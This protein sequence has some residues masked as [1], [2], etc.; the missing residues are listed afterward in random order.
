MNTDVKQLSKYLISF[1]VWL[2]P[3]TQ[4]K[5]A[6]L[7]G[8]SL[9]VFCLQIQQLCLRFPSWCFLWLLIGSLGFSYFFDYSRYWV[10][11]EDLFLAEFL[12]LFPV[13][14]DSTIHFPSVQVIH[15]KP[16]IHFNSFP[17][18][19]SNKL[20]ES[21]IDFY[22]WNI[23]S[24]ILRSSI[25]HPYSTSHTSISIELI[26]LQVPPTSNLFLPIPVYILLT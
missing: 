5:K 23:F 21:P 22:I 12:A 11:L 25:L 4:H 1:H 24:F 19:S 20:V 2:P 17:S 6:F 10:S 18:L 9:K 7:K 16:Q 26:S 8:R 3:S 13:F 14:I 15:S